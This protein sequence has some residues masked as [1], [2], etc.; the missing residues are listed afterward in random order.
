[1]PDSHGQ[2]W[3]QLVST[4]LQD[5]SLFCG[6]NAAVESQMLDVLQLSSEARFPAGRLVTLWKNERW[7]A[8]I[9]RWCETSIGRDMFQISTWGWMAS[10]RIDDVSRARSH[11]RV[12][13]QGFLTGQ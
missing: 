1:M 2:I 9:T 8:M 12:T 7:K 11:I 3:N 5:S 4:A 10:C 6:T 13:R